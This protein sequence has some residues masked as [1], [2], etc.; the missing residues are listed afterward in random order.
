MA[1]RDEQ[2]LEIS[3]T[4]Q[5]ILDPRAWSAASAV[6]AQTAAWNWTA[7]DMP[8]RWDAAF[9]R[10]AL[11]HIGGRDGMPFFQVGVNRPM[12]RWISM[13]QRHLRVTGS[14]AVGKQVN[15]RVR[16]PVPGVVKPRTKRAFAKITMDERARA[17][18]VVAARLQ[19]ILGSGANAAV[20]R[21]QRRSLKRRFMPIAALA[22]R[23]AE[24]KLLATEAHVKSRQRSRGQ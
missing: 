16:M 19:S 5:R 12:S 11:G 4:A 21:A 2:A 23:R 24:A 13:A 1:R 15:A 3:A 7:R 17:M 20:L 14:V 6:A 22:L 10:S 8:N 9:A 18:A